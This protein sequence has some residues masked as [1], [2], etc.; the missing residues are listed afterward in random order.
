[1]LQTF[2]KS[3]KFLTLLVMPSQ[4]APIYWCYEHH[5]T[6]ILVLPAQV[7]P[8][9]WCYDVF[10]TNILVLLVLAATISAHTDLFTTWYSVQFLADF[11]IIANRF[12][13]SGKN[14]E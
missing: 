9:Y 7:A 8:I 5:S 14:N 11:F 2:K 4:V 6:N 10:G 13:Q 12:N 1:V 3:A